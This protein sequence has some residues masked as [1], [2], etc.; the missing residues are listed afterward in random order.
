MPK[1]ID[2]TGQ[3]FG[4]LTA[5]R[6]ADDWFSRAG[7][8][9]TRWLCQCACGK[10]TTVFRNSV[11]SG[12]TRSC[13]CLKI[14]TSVGRIPTHGNDRHHHVTAEYTAWAH[15]KQRCYNERGKAWKNYGGRGI[16]VC[17]RWKTSFEA[18]LE[19]MGLRPSPKFTLERINNDLGYSPDNCIWGTRSQQNRNRR[20]FRKVKS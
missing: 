12:L 4:R 8:R 10:T 6:R 5:L 19:D 15:A 11:V 14:E 1:F 9:A 18:F 3:V 20:P 16:T 13:G 17:E 7:K 2:L